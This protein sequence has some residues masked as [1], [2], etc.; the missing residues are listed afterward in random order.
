MKK[1]TG[2]WL[3]KSRTSVWPS[4]CRRPTSTST[5]WRTWWSSTKRIRRRRRGRSGRSRNRFDRFYLEFGLHHAD[6]YLASWRS[7]DL[8][9]QIQ[10]YCIFFGLSFCYVYYFDFSRLVHLSQTFTTTQYNFVIEMFNVVLKK[11]TDWLMLIF[12]RRWLDTW[13]RA[14]RCRTF[15]SMSRKFLPERSW[16]ERRPRWHQSSKTGSKKILATSKYPETRWETSFNQWI[17]ISWRK[18][19]LQSFQCLS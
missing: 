3:I 2:S 6:S 12:R 8:I 14:L 1:A 19:N 4:C 15:E 13:T 18:L 11:N 7:Y 9:H 10:P 16:E 5:S 17:W